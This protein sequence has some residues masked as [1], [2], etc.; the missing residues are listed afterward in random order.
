VAG[1]MIWPADITAGEAEF[2][3][4]VQMKNNFIAAVAPWVKSKIFIRGLGWIS[5]SR[6]LKM[7]R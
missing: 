4:T 6:Q 7:P 2:P 5:V 1:D 3:V